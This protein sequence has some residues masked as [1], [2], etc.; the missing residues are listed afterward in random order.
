[1]AADRW[2]PLHQVDFMAG[3]G[4]LQRCLYASDAGADDQGV[5]VN[6]NLFGLQRL[7]VEQR[8]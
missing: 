5:R 6:G 4:N 8:A 2:L 3:I 1:M 7:V